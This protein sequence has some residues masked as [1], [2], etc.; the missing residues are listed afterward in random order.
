MR[1]FTALPSAPDDNE[2]P[3]IVRNNLY[4]STSKHMLQT[5]SESSSQEGSTQGHS[6]AE[7]EEN[8]SEV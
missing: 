4:I 8:I 6:L 2:Q 1:W 3:G 7:E 5:S